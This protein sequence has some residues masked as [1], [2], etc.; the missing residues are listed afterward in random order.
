MT[1][2]PPVPHRV[3]QAL[4]V[5]F[6]LLLAGMG[7][8]AGPE[9]VPTVSNAGVA[10]T[11][12]LYKM[13]V[14][15]IALILRETEQLTSAPYG[16]NFVPEVLDESDLL[17][18][19][20]AVLTFS[21]PSVFLSFFGLPSP[22]VAAAVRAAGRKLVVQVGTVREASAAVELGTDVIVLQGIEAGGHLLGGQFTQALLEEVRVL[23]PS[24][25]IA[26][27]GGVATG[28]E[29]ARLSGLGADGICCGTLFIPTLESRAHPVYKQ[30]VLRARARDTEITNLFDIGWPRRR[31]RVIRTPRVA[32]G[33]C[34]PV[35]FIARTQVYGRPC[36]ISRYSAAV[37][38]VETTGAVEEMAL[39]CGTSCHQIVDADA[40]ASAVVARFVDGYG[41]A[42]TH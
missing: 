34:D 35:A 18:R 36:L 31:H 25:T 24:A 13:P 3:C 5:K 29:F 20:Q 4:N 32:D 12:G 42:A 14:D 11:L 6:P 7:G 17:A 39:Y 8:V 37:P 21:R 26:V 41:S 30:E 2:T 38:T 28:E 40:S 10:G 19:V 15:H 33:R 9:L 16:A 27:A 23:L 1:R 22:A